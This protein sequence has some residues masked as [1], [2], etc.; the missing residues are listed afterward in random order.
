MKVAQAITSWYNS[1]V[2]HIGVFVAGQVSIVKH[3]LPCSE[4]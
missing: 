1:M 2:Q 3:T 4:A